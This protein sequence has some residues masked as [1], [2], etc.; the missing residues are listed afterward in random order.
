MLKKPTG[1]L[2]DEEVRN[3]VEFLQEEAQGKIIALDAAPTAT[4]PLLS[5]N[6][7]GQYGNDFWYRFNDVLYQFTSDDQ[8]TIT[9]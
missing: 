1:L 4:A 6:E 3:H 5:E 7:W 9:V 8:I 2:K